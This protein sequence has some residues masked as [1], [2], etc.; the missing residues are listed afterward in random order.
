MLLAVTLSYTVD[1]AQV[2]PKIWEADVQIPALPDLQQFGMR[3]SALNQ[4][5]Q[6]LVFD[7]ETKYPMHWM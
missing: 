4:A 6:R 1:W 3:N 7:L 2:L 5:E